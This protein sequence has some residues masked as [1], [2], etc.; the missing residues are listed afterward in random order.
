MISFY[1]DDDNGLNGGTDRLK[2]SIALRYYLVFPRRC[3]GG[4]L[5]YGEMVSG[6]AFITMMQVEMEHYE[7]RAA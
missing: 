5:G 1:C 7:Q 3:D 4:L 6:D 2:R